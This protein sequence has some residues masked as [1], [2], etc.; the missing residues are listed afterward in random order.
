MCISVRLSSEVALQPAPAITWRTIG[1]I[2]DFYVFTG[3]DPASVIGQY[4]EVIGQFAI[5]YRSSCINRSRDADCNYN[6]REANRSVATLRR[7]ILLMKQ[8]INDDFFYPNEQNFFS[9]K[10]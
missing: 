9:K 5:S 4:V 3:P 1:G 8:I 2:L 7:I 10:K 6:Y